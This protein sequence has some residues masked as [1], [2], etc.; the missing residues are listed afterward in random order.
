M[1]VNFLKKENEKQLMWLRKDGKI[2]PKRTTNKP[3]PVKLAEQKVQVSEATLMVFLKR[4]S[5]IANFGY[6]FS[7]NEIGKAVKGE[8]IV[9]DI[10]DM[11]VN[12]QRLVVYFAGPILS[13]SQ[14]QSRKFHLTPPI[15]TDQQSLVDFHW[16]SHVE[17]MMPSLFEKLAKIS[18]AKFPQVLLSVYFVGHGVGGA[19]ATLAA[20]CFNRALIAGGLLK[21]LGFSPWHTR[22]VTFGA[23]R[24]GNLEFIKTLKRVIVFEKVYRVTHWNDWLSREMLPKDPFL[25]YEREFW[26]DYE[27]AD[28]DCMSFKKKPILFKCIGR[29][30]GVIDENQECNLGTVDSEDPDDI[31]K[32]NLGPYFGT[33]FTNCTIINNKPS[34]KIT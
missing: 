13:K 9:A 14:W 20:M 25:H 17:Q 28:C 27:K 29:K 32:I 8:N 2:Y 33:I 1:G 31:A 22:I 21:D 18:Q 5:I 3:K 11:S 6:C 4:M 26:L 15:Q 23:P 7:Q 19:Y 12:N 16:L 24:V 10:W 34:I 30:S